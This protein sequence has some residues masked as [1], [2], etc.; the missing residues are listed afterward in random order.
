MERRTN[1]RVASI[2]PSSELGQPLLGKT[3]RSGVAATRTPTLWTR[4]VSGLSFSWIAGSLGGGVSLSLALSLE[5]GL[6]EVD[7]RF[8]AIGRE[9]SLP[10]RL[11]RVFGPAMARAAAYKLAAVPLAAARRTAPSSADRRPARSEPRDRGVA[12]ARRT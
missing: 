7:R 8:R 6:A 4:L 5:G 3:P 2:M 9:R 12:C 1:E 11:A 10:A